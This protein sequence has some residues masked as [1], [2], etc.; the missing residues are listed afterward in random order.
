MDDPNILDENAPLIPEQTK[1]TVG[2]LGVLMIFSFFMFTLPF[3]AFYG[4]KSV[5]K[6]Y[7]LLDGFENTVW[8]VIA[9][10]VTVN[11]IIVVYAYLAFKEPDYDKD[12]NIVQHEKKDKKSN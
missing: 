12:G 5:L 8:S 2:V 3:G 7:F 6:Y 11:G 10:V 1:R 4:T 9:S